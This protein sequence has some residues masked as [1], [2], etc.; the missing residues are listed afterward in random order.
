[1][2][3]DVVILMAEDDEGH[4]YLVKRNLERAGIT[5]QIEHFKNGE[6]ILSFLNELTDEDQNKNKSFL[7]LLDIRMPRVDGIEVL[8]K[9]KENSLLKTIPVIMLTTT[10]N[11]QEIKLCHSLGCSNYITKPIEYEKF[12]ETIRRLGLFMRIVEIPELQPSA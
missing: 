1:M 6:E 9:I 10:N 3:N 2:L 11:P 5:N 7:I 12:V 4:A 8:K